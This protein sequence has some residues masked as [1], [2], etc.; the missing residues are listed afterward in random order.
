MTAPVVLG[1]V[2]SALW[3]GEPATS[4]KLG[5]VVGAATLSPWFGLILVSVGWARR[6]SR[7][8]AFR[9]SQRVAA[10]TE[11]SVLA[12]VL[13]M[14]ISSGLSVHGALEHAHGEVSGRVGSEVAVVLKQ[15]RTLGLASALLSVQGAATPLFSQ[16]AGASASGGPAA[17]VVAAFLHE[18][19]A[20]TRAHRLGQMRKLPVKLTV[21]ITL[22]ILPGC[23]LLFVGPGFVR[24]IA[25]LLPSFGVL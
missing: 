18:H 14:G 23:V 22:L 8:V 25:D 17:P 12:R 16:L 21:P 15:F 9:R 7:G 1:L 10:T 13:L 2:A 20:T 11:L 19:V 5:W 24:G 6:I 3:R 4:R